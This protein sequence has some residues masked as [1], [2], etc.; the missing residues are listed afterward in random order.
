V[1]LEVA[2]T[3]R[4]PL[5][6][7]TGA[8]GAVGPKVLAAFRAAGYSIR[9]LSLD[10]P[11]AGAWPADVDARIGDVTDPAA[12]S[13]ALQGAD[14]VVHMAALLHIANP[15]PSLQDRYDRINVGGTQAVAEAAVQAGVRRVVLFSTIAV[16][17]K[18]CG[19]VLTEDTPPRPD[20]FYARSKLAAEKIVL[21]A[22]DEVGGPIGVVLRLGA[23][24]GPRIKGN[25]HRL[26]RSLAGGRFIPIGD[27]SNRR[28]LIYDKDVGRA[29]VLAATHANAAGRIFNVTDGQSHS[30]KT[31]VA[32]LCAALGRKPPGFALPL[33]PVLR[34]AGML[35]GALKLIRLRS[36]VTADIISKYT[37]DM[38]VDSGRIRR[39]LGFKPDYD[40]ASGWR[41]TVQ[42]MRRD[43][44]L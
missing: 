31:I 42:A 33:A 5:V 21:A 44:L 4:Q 1:G 9:T 22:K 10:P 3:G 25:Y 16:Y 43:G 39:E 27:G 13:S 32:S 38:A 17:G 23:V 19:E 8:T 36:P 20:T 37:E 30:M 6:L 15:P 14:A 2:V 35:E 24:Y 41:E 11:P 28:A 29:A 40:L 12:A 18:S 7:I 34:A 26:L